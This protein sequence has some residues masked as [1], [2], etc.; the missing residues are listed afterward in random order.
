M[1]IPFNWK[2]PCWLGIQSLSLISAMRI[3]VACITTG[4][5]YLWNFLIT[6]FSTENLHWCSNSHL[7]CESLYMIIFPH[8]HW[9]SNCQLYSVG[10]VIWYFPTRTDK[11]WKNKKKKKT[12]LA[13][14]RFNYCWS[15][16]NIL[17][18]AMVIIWVDNL[19]NNY[20]YHNRWKIINRLSGR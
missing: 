10:Y 9:W 15:I 16:A 11:I 5:N 3:G 14:S 1:R 20:L 17:A 4:D 19:V 8:G 7:R 2:L 18:T 12:A 13:V 6:T